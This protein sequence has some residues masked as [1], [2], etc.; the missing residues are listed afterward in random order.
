M[1]T[2]I[3]GNGRPERGVAGGPVGFGATRGFVRLQEQWMVIEV[4]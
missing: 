3:V 2:A 4:G 1:P